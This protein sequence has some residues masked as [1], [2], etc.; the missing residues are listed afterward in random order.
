MKKVIQGVM[1]SL[2][3]IF[4][5]TFNTK[6]DAAASLSSVTTGAEINAITDLS[7]GNTN[8]SVIVFTLNNTNNSTGFRLTISSLKTGNLV[9]YIAP[10]YQTM[11]N[12]GN[13]APYTFSWVPSTVSQGTLGWVEPSLPTNASLASPVTIDYV[14]N[15]ANTTVNYKYKFVITIPAKPALF[16]GT[17][18]DSIT[19]TMV[20]F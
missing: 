8:K 1:V 12:T 6:I 17:F 20:D 5:F 13:V 15:A 2:I 16:S 7:L 14:V 10:N 19:L 11:T 3:G 18:R 4:L 9:R